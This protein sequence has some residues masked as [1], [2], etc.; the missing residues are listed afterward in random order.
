MCWV[1]IVEKYS[2]YNKC[3]GRTTKRIRRVTKFVHFTFCS[4]K[5][6]YLLKEIAFNH[7]GCADTF[8]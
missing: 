2:K 5:K 8:Y 6:L 1:L 4:S 7:F 3:C